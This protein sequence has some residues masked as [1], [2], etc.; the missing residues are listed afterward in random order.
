MMIRMWLER[1]PS[2]KKL[3]DSIVDDSVT[4]MKYKV[5]S[6]N[7]QDIPQVKRRRNDRH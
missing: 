2:H 4:L 7:T 1:K 6:N 5:I 3:F